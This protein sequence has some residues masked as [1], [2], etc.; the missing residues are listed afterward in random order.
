MTVLIRSSFIPPISAQFKFPPEFQ[1]ILAC[2]WIPPDTLAALQ[3]ATVNT[4][5][6]SGIG[7]NSFV[8]LIERHKVSGVAYTILNR[9]AAPFLPDDFKTELESRKLRDWKTAMVY[10]AELLRLN[11]SF[12]HKQIDLLP[13][14]GITLSLRLF[15]DPG[16]RHVRD[17]DLLV[18][19]DDVDQADELLQ[20]DGYRR[21]LPELQTTSERRRLQLRHE[22]HLEYYRDDLRVRLELHWKWDMLSAQK[23]SELWE[24]VHSLSWQGTQIKILDDDLLLLTLCDHGAGHRFMRLKWLSDCVMMLAATPPSSWNRVLELAN[25]LDMVRPLAAV[26]L[27]AKWLYEVELPEQLTSLICREKPTPRMAQECVEHMLAEVRNLKDPQGGLTFLQYTLRTPSEY[28]KALR[29]TMLLRK[30]SRLRTSLGRDL[31]RSADFD[32]LPLPDRL[33]WLYY[34]LRPLLWIWRHA[35]RSRN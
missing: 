28:V 23:V 5:C 18:R 9:N 6:R 10:S 20:A 32:A 4:L 14:K 13:L 24:H 2:S 17:L 11:K 15:G 30:K 7:W 29:Y 3:A 26:A 22:R 35:T 27:L 25:H 19:P 31:I 33:S 34:P 12:S 16:M 1:L 21:I 8:S